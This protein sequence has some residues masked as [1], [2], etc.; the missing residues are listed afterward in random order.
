MYKVLGRNHEYEAESCEPKEEVA[1]ALAHLEGKLGMTSDDVDDWCDNLV[2]LGISTSESPR[3]EEYD[4][5]VA[6]D[7]GAQS[8]LSTYHDNELIPAAPEDDDSGSNYSTSEDIQGTPGVFD[9]TPSEHATRHAF[10]FVDR[11]SRIIDGATPGSFAPRRNA[12]FQRSIQHLAKQRQQ[13]L[14]SHPSHPAM[15]D[16]DAEALFE[17]YVFTTTPSHNAHSSIQ[18]PT[19]HPA[20]RED[21]TEDAMDLPVLPTS[22]VQHTMPALGVHPALRDKQ[23]EEQDTL[24]A[25]PMPPSFVPSKVRSDAA[26]PSQQESDHGA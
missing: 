15:R 4:P 16:D 23:V 1:K 5:V 11:D 7:F 26:A 20:L 2:G 18:A 19:G 6:R 8:R 14:Q 10:M 9:A 25:F 22:L 21:D 3:I 13:A 24:P 12:K 17:S